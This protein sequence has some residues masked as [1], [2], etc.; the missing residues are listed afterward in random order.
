MKQAL[1]VASIFDVTGSCTLGVGVAKT[2]ASKIIDVSIYDDEPALYALGMFSASVGAACC[3]GTATK[4]GLPISTTHA[5]IGAVVG[6][7]FVETSEGV[8]WWG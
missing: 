2:I 4:M 6:F 5:V 3:V 1:I 7:S 8:I